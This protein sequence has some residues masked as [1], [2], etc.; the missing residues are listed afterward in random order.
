MM[1]GHG[2]DGEV[3]TVGTTDTSPTVDVH[4]NS[5]AE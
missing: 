5:V 3:R 4:V 1:H 2:R